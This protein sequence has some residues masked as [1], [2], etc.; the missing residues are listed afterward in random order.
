[1]KVIIAALAL[2]AI[3]AAAPTE[4]K[5]QPKILREE[6]DHKPDGGYNYKRASHALKSIIIISNYRTAPPKLMPYIFENIIAALA[7]LALAAAFP[8]ENKEP[9]K[10]LRSEHEQR[11]EGQYNF[12]FETDDGTSRQEQ[13]SIKEV[14]D[15]KKVPQ[16]V[17]VVRGFYTY[18]SEGKPITVEYEA[19]EN[20][21]RAFSDAI[22]KQAPSRR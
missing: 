2:V 14:L 10:I 13:G 21:Y 9:T 11:P 12:N 6:Y 8:L 16:N 18:V 7:L 20:G 3:A 1:M 4:Y 5:P 17:V 19:D 22:P 15:E